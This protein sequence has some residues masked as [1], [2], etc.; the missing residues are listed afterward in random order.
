MCHHF[1]TTFSVYTVFFVVVVVVFVT[2]GR[3]KGRL[4][5]DK[6]LIFIGSPALLELIFVPNFC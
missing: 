2:E 1:S 4:A 6:K 3:S 5:S